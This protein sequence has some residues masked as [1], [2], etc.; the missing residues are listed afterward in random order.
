LCMRCL[1]WCLQSR[2]M[3]SCVW[4]ASLHGQS[5][6]LSGWNRLRYSPVYV[7]PVLH[8]MSRPNV[9]CGVSRNRLVGLRV[10]W[11]QFEIANAPSFGLDFHCFTQAFWDAIFERL[12]VFAR[13]VLIGAF[14]FLPAGPRRALFKLKLELPSLLHLLEWNHPARIRVFPLSCPPGPDLSNLLLSGY[15]FLV[16][17]S[18]LKCISFRCQYPIWDLQ[19][20]RSSH[21]YGAGSLRRA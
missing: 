15:P 16:V 1:L 10:G 11:M 6:S 21:N 14:E 9:S 13:V 7:C 18:R 4:Y 3:C 8:C 19:K 12:T 2:R 5:S 17:S 20:S